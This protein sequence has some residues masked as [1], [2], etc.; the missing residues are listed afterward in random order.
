MR[1]RSQEEMDD[2]VRQAG[3]KKH[4]MLV[5]QWGIFTVSLAVKT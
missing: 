1:L 3:F 2:L 5:D 4:E